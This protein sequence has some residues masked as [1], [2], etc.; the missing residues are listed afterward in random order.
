MYPKR[1]RIEIYY[2]ETIAAP[3][4]TS[5][6]IYQSFV[7]PYIAYMGHIPQTSDPPFR[8]EPLSR[9]SGSNI[10]EPGHHAL[11]AILEEFPKH[12]MI[13]QS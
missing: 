6:G 8:Q 5:V 3:K 7:P 4:R 9:L 10:T 12:M 2:Y 11:F 13:S 1:V